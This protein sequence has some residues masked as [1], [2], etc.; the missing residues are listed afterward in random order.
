MLH[1]TS[2]MRLCTLNETC[3]FLFLGVDGGG[4]GGGGH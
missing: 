1:Y 4:G 2:E 3:Q